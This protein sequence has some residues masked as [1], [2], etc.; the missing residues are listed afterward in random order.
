M[1]STKMLRL[2]LRFI[3]LEALISL[4]CF[5]RLSFCY[6]RK[7]NSFF[8]TNISGLGHVLNEFVRDVAIRFV[9]NQNPEI[10]KAA[11]LTCCQLFI[12]DPII[13]QTSFHA[14]SVVSEVIS[15]LLSV[16]VGDPEPDIR[17]TI[18]CS[19]DTKF[20]RHLA[21]PENIRMLVFAINEADYEVRQA[22]MIILGRLAGVNPAYVFPPLRKLLVNLMQGVKSSD[23]STHEE[24]GAKLISLCIANA[25]MII[26]PYVNSLVKILLP[27]ATD[28]N[29]TVASTVMR[30]LGDLATVGGTELL[31]YIP[32]LMPTIIDAL[33]D[34]SSPPKR[35]SALRALGQLA[36]N[37]GYVI[38][39]YLDH[40]HLLD[41]LVNIIKT[42]QQGSL[43]RETIK[44]MGIF[45]ALD[46]YKHQVCLFAVF[47]CSQLLLRMCTDNRDI[48]RLH[49][50]Y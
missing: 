27:K 46:P 24:E 28:A 39:P 23:D 30:A 12:N 1:L 26:K 18:L 50:P 10:R 7:K 47:R 29:A 9:E 42:E 16:A 15:K 25:P 38:Q 11:A 43:R 48:G 20:D 34:L 49:R 32:K 37:S 17:R 21:H 45:G 8:L 44:L 2:R 40:P 41:L 33:Q 14:I 31:P 22:A 35:D 36:S 5:Y 13:H 6:E 19:L 3:L 4:V